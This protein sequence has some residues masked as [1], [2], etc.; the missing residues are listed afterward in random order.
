KTNEKNL[1]PEI[2]VQSMLSFDHGQVVTGRNHAAVKDDEVI[3][4]G[5]K[6]NALMA[7]GSR[8]EQNYGEDERR[9]S[10]KEKLFHLRHPRGR[11]FA[12]NYGYWCFYSTNP[13][14][15]GSFI[16]GIPG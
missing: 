7:G 9:D 1:R 3:F 13:A 2:L 5:T 4:A 16:F 15:L 8:K 10:A 6:D 14:L 12:N 11:R